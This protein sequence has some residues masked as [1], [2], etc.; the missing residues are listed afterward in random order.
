ML[1]TDGRDCLI[2]TTTCK[3]VCV[4][5][6]LDEH[7][8]TLTVLCQLKAQN[9]IRN[10]SCFRFYVILYLYYVNTLVITVALIF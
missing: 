9:V 6:H 1:D 2:D 4:L 7:L 8:V 3:D 10:Q 5:L